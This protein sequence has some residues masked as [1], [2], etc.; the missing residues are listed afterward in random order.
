[1]IA[2]AHQLMMEVLQQ[3]FRVTLTL[4]TKTCQLS[5]RLLTTAT[6]AVTWLRSWTLTRT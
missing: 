2:R 1:M 4:I 3:R 6:D 5:F